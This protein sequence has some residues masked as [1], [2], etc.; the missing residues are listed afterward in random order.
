MSDAMADT[1]TPDPATEAPPSEEPAPPDTDATDP[2]AE[3]EKWK[4][5]A[6]KHE[7]RAKDNAT[8]AKELADL[9]RSQMTEQERAVATARDEARSEV[10]R[11]V[12]T[13]RVDDAFRV[14][15]AG[16]DVDDDALLEGLD[17]AAF[18]NDEGQP[19]RDRIG[20]WVDRIAPKTEPAAGFVDLG[21]GA[22]PAGSDALN[23]DPL[24]RDLKSKLGIG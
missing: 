20:A 8:A 22:R 9:K 23:G 7:Q 17:K 10:L 2:T 13:Q 4:A 16:R 5:L 1:A 3:A 24:L 21:Q 12:G 14:A 15:L 19:D 6:K 11:E 18:L